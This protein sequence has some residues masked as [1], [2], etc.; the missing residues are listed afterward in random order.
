MIRDE[1][2]LL[3]TVATVPA[4]ILRVVSNQLGRPVDS[5]YAAPLLARSVQSP[6]SAATG[7]LPPGAGRRTKKHKGMS[8]T[9]SHAET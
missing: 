2:A 4:G 8:S 6:Y 7:A 3:S 9:L 5:W 1:C